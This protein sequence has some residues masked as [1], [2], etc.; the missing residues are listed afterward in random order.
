MSY[1]IIVSKATQKQIDDL[2]QDIQE[3]VDEKIQSL[4]DEPRP[5]GTVKLKGS[6]NEYRLRVGDYRIRYRIDDAEQTIRIS[7]CRHR[8][9][10]YRK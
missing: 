4:A 2:P 6:K 3:R 5:S 9:D 1:V 8:R 7:Q 10:V